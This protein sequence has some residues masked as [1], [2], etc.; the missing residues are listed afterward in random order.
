MSTWAFLAIYFAGAVIFTVIVTK[1]FGGCDPI[2]A[3]AWPIF[4][5]GA[6]MLLIPFIIWGI[7]QLVLDLFEIKTDTEE[8]PKEHYDK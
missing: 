7:S 6:A 2:I 3:M 5:G 8:K 4:V 1:F